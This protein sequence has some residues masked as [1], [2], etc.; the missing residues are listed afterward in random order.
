MTP[1]D[2]YIQYIFHTPQAVIPFANLPYRKFA[3]RTHKRIL[4]VGVVR[5]S[6]DRNKQFHMTLPDGLECLQRIEE[7]SQLYA[8]NLVANV[9]CSNTVEPFIIEFNRCNH[10]PTG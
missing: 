6:H 9:G 8:C 1:L 3:S 7:V 5:H 10:F 4:F 2:S